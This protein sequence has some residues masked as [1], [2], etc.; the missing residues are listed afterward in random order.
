MKGLESFLISVFPSH[1]DSYP[2]E[3]TVQ[4]ILNATIFHHNH[5]HKP[6]V[7]FCIIVVYVEYVNG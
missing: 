4:H 2:Q 7:H 6:L 1:F 3:S 5:L